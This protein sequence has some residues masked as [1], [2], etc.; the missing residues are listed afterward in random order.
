M[1]N[2]IGTAPRWASRLRRPARLASMAEHTSL[3]PWSFGYLP[4]APAS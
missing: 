4:A 2:A 1:I 3:P